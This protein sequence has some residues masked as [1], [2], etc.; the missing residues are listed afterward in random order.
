MVSCQEGVDEWAH[1]HAV[2]GDL[3]WLDPHDLPGGWVTTVGV[4]A[5]LPW[6]RRPALDLD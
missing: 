1:V 3:G 5:D 4:E 2:A 6:D